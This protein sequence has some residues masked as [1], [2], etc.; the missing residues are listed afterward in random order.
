[1]IYGSINSD[2]ILSKI[3][4]CDSVRFNSI[5]YDFNIFISECKQPGDLLFLL[6][7]SG[8]MGQRNFDAAKSFV[9]DVTGKLEVAS[10]KWQIA[11]IRFST[12]PQLM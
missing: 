5:R 1:M 12:N 6:D 10:D 7:D 2:T 9:H 4:R 11:L 3:F 8:S